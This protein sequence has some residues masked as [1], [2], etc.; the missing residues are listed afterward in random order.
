MTNSLG[1]R[2]YRDLP[3]LIS[4]TNPFQP[5]HWPALH[6]ALPLPVIEAY[7]LSTGYEPGIACIEQQDY[8][9]GTCIGCCR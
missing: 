4:I 8:A 2:V 1:Y 7:P 5:E 9:E 6:S 3:S